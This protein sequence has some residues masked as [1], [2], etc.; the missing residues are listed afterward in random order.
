MSSEKKVLFT[1]NGFE[2]KANSIYKIA[3]KPD[4][5]APSGFQALGVT[6]LPS[7]G[8]DESFQV[9]FKEIGSNG[10]GV[11]DTGFSEYS[12]CYADMDEAVVKAQVKVLKENLLK[13]YI[14]S[15]GKKDAFEEG[16]EEFF[17]KMNFKVFSGQNLNTASIHDR[18]TLYFA[19]RAHQV[20]PEG[21]QGDSKYREAAYVIVDKN[22][23]VNEKDKRRTMKFNAIGLFIT[24]YQ[25][26]RERLFSILTWIG[27]NISESTDQLTL[28]G[29]FDEYLQVSPDRAEAFINTEKESQTKIGLEKL[30]VYKKL[31][32]TATKSTKITKIPNGSYFY[33]GDIELGV[34]LKSSAENIAKLASLTKVK[35]DLLLLDEIED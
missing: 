1:V 2:V 19:L 10:D 22:K 28:N 13:P 15:T 4:G 25:Q 17:K 30:L 24:L 5:D 35:K 18:M 23:A 3:D 32:E 6:K 29:M 14:A 21:R 27:F 26:D 7:A 20:A 33:E 11:W 12:P 9:P 31:R 34:D 8:V 16:N